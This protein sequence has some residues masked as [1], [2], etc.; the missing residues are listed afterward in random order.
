M[1]TKLFVAIMAVFLFVPTFQAMAQGYGDPGIPDTVRFGCPVIKNPIVVGDSIALPV[2]LFNDET[3]AGMSLG[4]IMDTSRV[5]FS[6][7]KGSSI[8]PVGS[9]WQTSVSIRF[10]YP[11]PDVPKVDSSRQSIIFGGTDL[12]ED[13]SASVPAVTGTNGQLIG[14]IYL[15]IREGSKAGW[16]DIDSAQLRTAGQFV[17]VHAF[18]TGGILDSTWTIKPQYRDCGTEDI[19]LGRTFLCGDAD[20][21]GIV[22]ITDAVW[23]VNFVFSGGPA[24]NPLESG[25]VDCS[26]IINVSDII[27]LVSYIF[28]GGPVPC[29]GC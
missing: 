16:Y 11:L 8:L 3:I 17:L 7:F 15:L 22:N 2:Y 10:Y 6:S 12:S 9:G 26:G 25:D 19:L 5:K 20:G 1:R 23:L 28:A 24:P 14:T 18:V 29:A 4:F 13:F 27:Y 21:N